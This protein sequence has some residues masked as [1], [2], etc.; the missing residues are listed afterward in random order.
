LA[1]AG[2]PETADQ[3]RVAD[4]EVAHIIALHLAGAR[5][6]RAVPGFAAQLT[7]LVA[8]GWAPRD[9]FDADADLVDLLTAEASGEG[10]GG[11]WTSIV[12]APKGTASAP[13]AETL[14]ALERNLLDRMGSSE[15]DDPPTP[16]GR[17]HRIAPE[18]PSSVDTP[19]PFRTEPEG[20]W[21]S[22]VGS[23]RMP[24]VPAP[25]PGAA[26]ARAETASPARVA[27][28]VIDGAPGA[29]VNVPR[30]IRLAWSDQSAGARPTADWPNAPSAR[31]RVEDPEPSGLPADDT[32]GSWAVSA[33]PSVASSLGS[34]SPHRATLATSH[35]APTV[36]DDTIA[37]RTAPGATPGQARLDVFALADQLA[38]LL[39]EESELR[40][41]RR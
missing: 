16:S 11:E 29:P 26:T 27:S 39:D 28:A 32:G 8:A 3:T 21:P 35:P 4:D 2:D 9:V 17:R 31:P 12:V 7:R 6:E 40:G 23:A 1:H 5:P 24:S 19:R 38:A 18:S 15:S 14:R 30:P 20:T 37:A 13:L 36:V 22:H 33:A 34:S 41:L 10:A 25:V